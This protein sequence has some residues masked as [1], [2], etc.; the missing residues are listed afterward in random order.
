M[1]YLYLS[2]QG[3]ECGGP[4]AKSKT[5]YRYKPGLQGSLEDAESGPRG[6]EEAGGDLEG[7][8]DVE[9]DPEGLEEAGGDSKELE[10]AK[11]DS[12]GFKEVI[13]KVLK[14]P[15]SIL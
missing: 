15:V 11:D 12:E 6:L 1:D 13:P 9:G 7:P 8:K 3:P 10:E 5:R 4:L 14:K 2:I